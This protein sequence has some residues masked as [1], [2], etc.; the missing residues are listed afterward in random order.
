MTSTAVHLCGCVHPDRGRGTGCSK[1]SSVLS[2]T[3]PKSAGPLGGG[4]ELLTAATVTVASGQRLPPYV[5]QDASDVL[6]SLTTDVYHRT[7]MV[8]GERLAERLN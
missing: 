3:R 7:L 2:S 1:I 4:G 6:L 5:F 8:V